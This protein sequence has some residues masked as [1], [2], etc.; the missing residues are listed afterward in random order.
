MP[1]LVKGGSGDVCGDLT[2]LGEAFL[3]IRD[4]RRGRTRHRYIAAAY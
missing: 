4:L 3:S 1:V 2:A